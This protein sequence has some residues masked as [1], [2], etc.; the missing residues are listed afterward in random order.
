ML[1]IDNFGSKLQRQET[2][3]K[4]GVLVL[5]PDRAFPA[6]EQEYGAFV[7]FVIF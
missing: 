7:G 5:L 1:A 2:V 4:L 3:H 6:D